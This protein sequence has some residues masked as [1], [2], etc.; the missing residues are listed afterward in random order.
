V[1]KQIV[2]LQVHLIEFDDN[3]DEVPP[4]CSRPPAGSSDTV[5]QVVCQ[6][7]YGHKAQVLDIV[8]SPTSTQ[9]FLSAHTGDD[10]ARGCTLWS[11]QDLHSTVVMTLTSPLE[12]LATFPDALA[13]RLQCF[14]C[15]FRRNVTTFSAD[16]KRSHKDVIYSA[17]LLGV[18]AHALESG[19]TR[20]VAKGALPH[21]PSTVLIHSPHFFKSCNEERAHLRT[22]GC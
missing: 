19:G 10:G 4:P 13:G 22:R 16:F 3:S 17:G 7:V 21:N 12:A 5:V 20:E 18:S 2:A 8:A 1:L 6:R 15:I 14:E 11:M 9:Q